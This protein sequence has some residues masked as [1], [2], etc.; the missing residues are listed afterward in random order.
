[1]SARYSFGAH[2]PAFWVMLSCVL[3]LAMVW[4]SVPA[5]AQ[6]PRDRRDPIRTK[7]TGPAALAFPGMN[8]PRSAPANDN[9]INALNL[10]SSLPVTQTVTSFEDA[11]IEVG[12]PIPT[13]KNSNNSS[14]WFS[15]TPSANAVV[16]LDGFG[17]SPD[18]L[19]VIAGVYTGAALG[20]LT[21]VAC[22]DDFDFDI[23]YYP[24]IKE[25][26]MTAGTTYY[27]QIIE[28]NNFESPA[29]SSVTV[30]LRTTPSAFNV[31]VN[32]TADTVD[33]VADD[34]VCAD[35][36]GFC[37]LRAAIMEANRAIGGS[38]ITIPAGNYV[39]TLFED[40]DEGVARE[41][42]L[43]IKE[44]M[45]LVGAGAG[46]T[47]I[48]ANTFDGVFEIFE[49]NTVNISGM[50]IRGGNRGYAGGGI[51]VDVGSVV[52]IT[53][54]NILYNTARD[55][56]GL[57]V[58]GGQAIVNNSAIVYNTTNFNDPGFGGGVGIF[59]QVDAET[60]TITGGQ[61]TLTNVTISNNTAQRGGGIAIGD[62]SSITLEFVTIADNRAIDLG[63]G[64]YLSNNDEG[65][66]NGAAA[67]GRTI[68][69]DNSSD[70]STA[71]DCRA[72][73]Y[74]R[75]AKNLIGVEAGC[76]VDASDIGG[77]NAHLRPLQLRGPG[78]TYAHGLESNS[79]AIDSLTTCGTSITD[80]RGVSRPI[81]TNCDIGALERDPRL[82]LPISLNAPA[83][84]SYVANLAS[85]GT[86]TWTQSS[87]DVY[88]Y[89][90]IITNV[91]V[92]PNVEVL[93]VLLR[94]ES[95]CAGGVCGYTPTVSLPD[96]FYTWTVSAGYDGDA[97]IATP[98]DFQ[99]DV[100]A[101]FTNLI[102][103]PG[104]EAKNTGWKRLRY[105]GDGAKC[106]TATVTIP[107]VEGICAFVFKGSSLENMALQQAIPFASL[108]VAA[109]DTF[110]LSYAYQAGLKTNLVVK[111]QVTYT[112]TNLTKSVASFK[113]VNT[114]GT[115]QTHQSDLVLKSNKVKAIKIIVNHKSKSGKAY[116]DKMRLIHIPA[117]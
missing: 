111:I 5:S 72:A 23:V 40:A 52:T 28:L 35:S 106:T 78:Y 47:I 37:S 96:N 71:P 107:T 22:N 1:M 44:N 108:G 26:S 48:D 63:G 49:D 87:A 43:D 11:T 114:N 30:T 19:D 2:R 4:A 81:N 90:F 102:T 50:S 42:D 6:S 20:S 12:E 25:I 10:G 41:G 24:F 67:L 54:V 8:S 62:Q 16:T 88:G 86:F 57:Y 68:V 7:P 36:S 27:I 59:Y 65:I 15:F 89:N 97:T 99:I 115:F 33:A 13:C 80:Q 84:D 14:I 82:P 46:L 110:R 66:G 98:R 74:T 64:L 104:F 117:S 83:D 69:A 76:T 73:G 79:P 92:S 17:S 105:T 91:G 39:R 109:N 31:T 29:G 77:L 61:A 113:V 93:N 75:N 95:A 55:G 21:S 18:N 58:R 34:G 103:N 85:L 38:T 112:P 60:T 94:T 3:L 56:S 100:F 9:F 116:I 70:T 32:T 53:D 51:R 101:G 45:T